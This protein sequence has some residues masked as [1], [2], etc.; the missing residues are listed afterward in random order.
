MKFV[1]LDPETAF[2]E[3]WLKSCII[4]MFRSGVQGNFLTNVYE[5]DNEGCIKI[6]TPSGITRE[7]RIKENL[8]QGTI[9]AAPIRANHIDKGMQ[10]AI[11]GTF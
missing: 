8:K 3:L 10:V 11:L 5:F 2:D 9:L 6:H 4:D 7:A 1:Y